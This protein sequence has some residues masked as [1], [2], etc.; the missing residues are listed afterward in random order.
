MG[1][2]FDVQLKFVRVSFA[3]NSTLTREEGIAFFQQIVIET[4]FL[5]LWKR[6]LTIFERW[7]ISFHRSS[8]TLY[9]SVSRPSQYLMYFCNSVKRI[10]S[11]HLITYIRVI[12]ILT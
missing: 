11:T 6:L 7:V 9:A 5:A 10:F 8:V 3:L 4:K 2:L 12:L 1:I